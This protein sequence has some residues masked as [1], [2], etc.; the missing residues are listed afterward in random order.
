MIVKNI[1]SLCRKRG[2]R[3][4]RLETELGFSHGAIRKW[5]TH[6]PTI[7]KVKSVADYFGIKVD[8]VLEGQSN[9]GAD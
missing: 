1:E 9:G 5:D 3:I 8:D 2:I 4:N 7:W 6:P